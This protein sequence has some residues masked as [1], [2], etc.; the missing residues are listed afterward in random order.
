M[1]E[2]LRKKLSFL[3]YNEKIVEKILT[4]FEADL[5]LP[6]DKKLEQLENA[7]VNKN[8]RIAEI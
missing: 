6:I 4:L 5:T 3:G 1:K 7:K 2:G 8:S